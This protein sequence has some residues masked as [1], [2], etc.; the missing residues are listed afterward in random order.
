M[1]LVAVI[2]FEK[3]DVKINSIYIHNDT[4]LMIRLQNLLP[5]WII[6]LP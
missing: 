3:R 1:V 6:D 5:K 4:R 2:S